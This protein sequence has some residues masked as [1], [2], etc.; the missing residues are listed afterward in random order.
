MKS[1]IRTCIIPFLSASILSLAISCKNRPSQVILTTSNVLGITQTSAVTGG[2]ITYENW[3][4]MTARGV[5][6]STT[7]DP[8]LE[9]YKTND[10]TGSGNFISTLTGLQPETDYY[11]RAYATSETDT[12]YGRNILFSTKGYET[13]TDIE[14]NVY[15]N[16]TVG[17]QTWMAENLKT[18]RYNDGSSIPLVKDETKWAGIS[19]PAYC[20]YKNDEDAFKPVYGALYNWYSISTGKLCPVGWH[21]PGDEEWNVLTIYLGGEDIAGGKLKETGSTYWVEPNTGATNESGFT[22]YPGGFRYID[23][24]FFDFGFSCYWWSSTEYSES[25]SWFRFIYYNDAIA[26]RFNNNKKNGFSV[27]CIK[28]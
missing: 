24:K 1:L 16:V 18:T 14:G 23:G 26:H 5:C 15:K 11:V 10:G 22:A 7:T 28:D 27:R 6:W 2:N 20:W 17:T 13:M 9:D 19:T 8:T 25:R 21:V 3:S 4:R 12:V